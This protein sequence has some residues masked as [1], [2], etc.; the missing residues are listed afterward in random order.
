MESDRLKDKFQ[1]I[2]IE[3]H[4]TAAW[5]NIEKEKPVSKVAIPSEFETKN[6]KDYVDTNQK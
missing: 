1:E 3:K 5:A 2:P 6:A 4:D